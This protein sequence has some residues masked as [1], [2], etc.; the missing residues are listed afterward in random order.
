MGGP[1]L[2][3]NGMLQWPGASHCLV[4]DRFRWLQ[5][6]IEEPASSRRFRGKII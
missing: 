3:L 1:E 4:R 5:L 6:L 2:P